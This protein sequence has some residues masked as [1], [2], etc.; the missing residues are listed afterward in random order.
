MT[1]PVVAGP[2]TWYKDIM[3]NWQKGALAG[4]AAVGALIAAYGLLIERVQVQ[5]DRYELAL[6]KPGLPS[7][8]LRILH[9]SDLHCRP[10]G[11]VQALKLAR[12]ER[13]LVGEEYDL[14]ALTGDL[15]NTTGGLLA[16][17]ALVDKLRP[18]LGTFACPGNRDYWESS[19][20]AIFREP[21]GDGGQWRWSNLGVSARRLHEFGRTVALNRHTGLQVRSNDA[22][23]MLTALEARGVQPLLNRAVRIETDSVDLWVAGVDDLT[24][25]TPDLGAALADVP[26]GASL[27]LL[28]HNPD[29]WL[30]PLVQRADVVLSGHTHGGQIM[31][32]LFGAIYMGAT[33]LSR[34]RPTGWFVRGRSRMFVSRGVGESFPF[35]LAARPQVAL[36]RLIPLGQRQGAG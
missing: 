14:V 1:L 34:R 4:T 30:H 6:D 15:I 3:R 27:I 35:R 20:S 28:A 33:H 24:H 7:E 31:L 17:L 19:L 5:L 26:E 25:G 16:L 2:E 10:R 18:R 8:G 29:I 12:L 11:P 13:L 22:P 23:A 36:V 21:S 32:P 9:L